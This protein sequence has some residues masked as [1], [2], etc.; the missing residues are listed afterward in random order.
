M[1]YYV[2]HH[3]VPPFFGKSNIPFL[4]CS[5]VPTKWLEVL[6][7][8]LVDFKFTASSKTRLYL[9]IDPS[10][11]SSSVLLLIPLLLNLNLSLFLS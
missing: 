9:D 1:A 4:V 5:Y 2:F 11:V 8:R 3:Q 7:P 10:P 6:N